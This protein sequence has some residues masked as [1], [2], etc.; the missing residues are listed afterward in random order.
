MFWRKQ[1]NDDDTLESFNIRNPQSP[2]GFLG[3]EG[4]N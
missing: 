2:K 4:D 1:K 3:R